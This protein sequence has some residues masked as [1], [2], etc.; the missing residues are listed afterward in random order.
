MTAHDTGKGVSIGN[1]EEARSPPTDR[2]GPFGGRD[3]LVHSMHQLEMHGWD[4]VLHV[5]DEIVAE[6][7]P[8]RELGEYLALMQKRPS[9]AKDLPV[10][11]EGWSGSR[12]RK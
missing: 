4:I 2:R 1:R 8:N 10:A 11:V 3:I 5:H 12:Y 7:E 6:D 9:W